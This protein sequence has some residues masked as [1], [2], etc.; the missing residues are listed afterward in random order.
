MRLSTAAAEAI[1]ETER[2]RRREG[3]ERLATR[4]QRPEGQEERKNE[5]R[6]QWIE[7]LEVLSPQAKV[8]LD[9]SGF[10]QRIS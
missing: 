2:Q 9:T 3:E 7:R 6:D 5:A 1:E 4:A 8:S 10:D